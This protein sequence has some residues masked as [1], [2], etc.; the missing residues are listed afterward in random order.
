M[1]I[2]PSEFHWLIGLLEGEGTFL[3]GPPSNPGLPIVRVS[4]TDRDVVQRVARLLDRAVVAL[5]PRRQHH[6]VPFAV[7]IKGAPAVDLMLA[8]HDFM[9]LKRRTQIQRA[10]RS[11]SAD[12]KCLILSMIAAVFK[13]RN[14]VPIRFG[15]SVGRRGS[16]LPQQLDG[17]ET[18]D[19]LTD[20]F[21]I[22]DLVFAL[23]VDEVTCL[24]GRIDGFHER[25][26]FRMRFRATWR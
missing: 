11:C 21:E 26:V 14:Y 3:A 13:S 10:I 24:A 6:K 5:R 8:V 4:M 12:G 18:Q 25:P 2:D 17:G 20:V 23:A 1:V 22:V 7:T 15:A 16:E 19:R 9:G